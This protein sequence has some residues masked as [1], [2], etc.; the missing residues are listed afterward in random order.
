MNS[1]WIGLP[2]LYPEERSLAITKS[3]Q[4]RMTVFALIRHEEFD[5]KRL[6]GRLI[7]RPQLRNALS[8]LTLRDRVLLELDMTNALRPEELFALR[9]RC[10]NH[11]EGTMCLMET[12]YRGK[13]RS[14]GKTKKSLGVVHVPNKLGDD[15][16]LWKQEC[17][18]PSP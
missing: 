7:E 5:I 11:T 4:I 2:L 18:D 1:R 16:W 12:V 13:I 14:S 8:T 15:L 3:P 17:P 9:W 10:Y 6:Q